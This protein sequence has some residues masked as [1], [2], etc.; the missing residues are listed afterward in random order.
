MDSFSIAFGPMPVAFFPTVIEWIIDD[1]LSHSIR[2]F[3]KK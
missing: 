3:D 2:I 1:V